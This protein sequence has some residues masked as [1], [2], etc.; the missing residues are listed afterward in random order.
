MS[1]DLGQP[2]V[3][4]NG[5]C[6]AG[7]TSVGRVL[8]AAPDGDTVSIGNWST[9]VLNV[10]IYTLQYDL[11]GDL[12]PVALLPRAPQLIVRARCRRGRRLTRLEPI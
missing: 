3:I 12:A 10:A 11:L 4:E 6:A 1:A 7:S 9:H 8:H 2:I 5:A